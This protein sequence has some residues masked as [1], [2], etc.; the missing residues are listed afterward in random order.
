MKPKL[1][2]VSLQPRQSFS[3]RHD[4]VPYFYKELHFH[5]E[6]EL[7]YIQKGS[8]T[9]F[10]GNHIQSFKAGDM[11]LV[12]QDIPHLWKCDEQYCKGNPKL[13]AEATVIHFLPCALGDQFFDLPEN[14][15]LQKLFVKAKQGISIHRKTK[16]QIAVLLQKLLESTG[17]QKI[18]LFLEILHLLSESNDLQL[19][20]KKKMPLLPADKDPD[21]MNDVVQHIL[22]H[23][24]EDISLKEIASIA[25]LTPNSFCRYFKIRANKTYS[26]FLTEVR[27]NHACKQLSETEKPVSEI[28]YES[29]FNNF[30]NFNRYFKQ[31]V[32]FTPNQYRKKYLE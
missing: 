27:I 5:P 11:I 31:I 20:N 19:I 23:F 24:N 2:K 4:V 7:V 12:G 9:Q 26:T 29:G 21:R 22:A 8:G 1:L 3:V 10:I 17:T 13:K 6:M 25:N 30:S 18:I 16:N 32:G 15:N 28:C 14:Q